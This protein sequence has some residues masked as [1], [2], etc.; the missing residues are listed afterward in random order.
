M[1]LSCIPRAIMIASFHDAPLPRRTPA[2]DTL[3]KATHNGTWQ[4]SQSSICGS[5]T[6]GQAG[7]DKHVDHVL[8]VHLAFLAAGSDRRF[9]FAVFADRRLNERHAERAA[10]GTDCIAQSLG[11]EVVEHELDALRG[12]ALQRRQHGVD[13]MC[14]QRDDDE[15][16]GRRLIE[17]IGGLHR[18]MPAVDIENTAVALQLVEPYRTRSSDCGDVVPACVRHLEGKR[19]ADPTQTNNSDAQTF[20][21]P[22]S[23]HVPAVPLPI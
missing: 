14:E 4:R 3:S 22:L 10:F 17:R 19:T 11:L 2:T 15:I 20:T 23:L 9:K 1:K 5:R 18:R 8:S 12:T 13:L 16:V 6:G 7:G 21:S